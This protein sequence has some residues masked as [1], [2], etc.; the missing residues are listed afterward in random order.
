MAAADDY[1]QYAEECMRWAV[2]VATDDDRKA[3]LD[4][5]RAWTEAALQLEG[6]LVPIQQ[7]TQSPPQHLAIS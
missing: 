5:A 3:F 4:M 1:H 2:D 6:V 7:D